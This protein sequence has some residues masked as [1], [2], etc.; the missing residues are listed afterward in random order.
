[1][2]P[3]K[4]NTYR[5]DKGDRTKILTNQIKKKGQKKS[6]PDKPTKTLQLGSW[7]TQ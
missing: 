4:K 6:K 7:I 5:N 3:V 2:E 1:M